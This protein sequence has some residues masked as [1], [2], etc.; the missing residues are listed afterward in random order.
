MSGFAKSREEAQEQEQEKP[1]LEIAKIDEGSY[2]NETMVQEEEVVDGKA[3][4]SEEQANGSE[5]QAEGPTVTASL[6]SAASASLASASASL[7]SAASAAIAPEN[8][9]ASSSSS[10]AGVK[11]V[12]PPTSLRFTDLQKE[13][14]KSKYLRLKRLIKALNDKI[15]QQKAKQDGSDLALDNLNSFKAELESKKDELAAIMQTPLILNTDPIY[16]FINNAYKRI[17]SFTGVASGASTIE[18]IVNSVRKLLGLPKVA[19][20]A[21]EDPIVNMIIYASVIITII[22]LVPTTREFFKPI[23]DVLQET[24]NTMLTLHFGKTLVEHVDVVVDHITNISCMLIGSLSNGVIDFKSRA[25]ERI[26]TFLVHPEVL[27]AVNKDGINT[28][29]N[30]LNAARGDIAHDIEGEEDWDERVNGDAMDEECADEED[31][32]LLGLMDGPELQQEFDEEEAVK[33][34]MSL[35]KKGS[36]NPTAKRARFDDEEYS[37]GRRKSK[38][39]KKMTIKKYKGGKRVTRRKGRK[40]RRSTK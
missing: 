11:S 24:L 6:A 3:V 40:S 39:A 31:A 12:K 4:G 28:G 30:M 23:L 10:E 36:N 33:A 37:G 26:H 34:L 29:E 9:S 7:A 32:M 17:L 20:G 1:E 14:Y 27:V 21:I 15:E 18:N 13:F 2:P 5:E 25:R 19:D 16:T 8:A 22:I 38:R 35:P